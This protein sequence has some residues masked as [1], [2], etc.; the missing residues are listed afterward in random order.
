MD[1]AQA[2]AVTDLI[3]AHTAQA[4]QCALAQ[5]AG[6]L[7]KRV[8]DI[9]VRLIG[10]I[11]EIE[12]Y[13]DF[14]DEDLPQE[15]RSR[16][17]NVMDNALCALDTLLRHARRGRSFRE[18]ARVAIAGRP[19]TGK[20]SLFNALL[21][22]ERAIVA[23]REGTTRD[24]L[25]ATIDLQG[26][27]TTLVDMA[28][29]RDDPEPIEA[30]GIQR[31]N[32]EI[33][34]AALTLFLLD[35]SQP[36]TH[37]DL[38]IYKRIRD[39]PHM[40][41]VN[42][43]DLPPGLR[44]HDVAKSFSGTAKIVCLEVSAQTCQGLDGLESGIAR[45]L[46]GEHPAGISP[47]EPLETPLLT[48]TRHILLIESGRAS[49]RR[50]CEGLAGQLPFELISVDL[51]ECLDFLGEITGRGNLSEEILDSIFSTFCLGK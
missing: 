13:I 45:F 30:L 2:E 49:L 37:A 41:V 9:R 7:S 28:G 18:G 1:L 50:A 48:N 27:P 40:L 43:R 26:I 12:A 44:S 34:S 14:P 35:G 10:V 32:E 29:L 16:L 22:R 38:Q 4:A 6:G 11:A 39:R 19:N 17:G 8:E 33:K 23:P 3:G 5:L 51:R 20:S 31:A 36:L 25:E 46:Q 42:K 15:D 47:S 24:T 21:G